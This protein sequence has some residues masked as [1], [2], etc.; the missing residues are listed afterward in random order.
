M[1]TNVQVH[2]KEFELLLEEDTIA[3]RIRLMAIQ[4]N[5]DYEN[6]EPLFIAVLNGSFLFM[7]D[8]MK[9][10]NLP[11][12]TEFI[13]VSSYHGTSSGGSVKDMMGMPTNIKGRDIII[14]EDI[15]DTGLTMQYILAEIYKLEPA[16]VTVCSLLFKPEALKVELPELTYVG[17]EIPNEFVVGYGLDYDGLGRNLNHIYRAISIEK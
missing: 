10:I 16:S 2:D 14:V 11:C 3:K 5:V 7:A 1:E 15:I 17:F 9:E 6:R 8:L 13:K 12:E 4:L